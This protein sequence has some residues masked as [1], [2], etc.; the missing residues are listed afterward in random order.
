MQDVTDRTVFPPWPSFTEEE[1]D[2]VAA[3]LRSNK[4]NYWTAGLD[5]E[6]G[7][8]ERAFAAWS[9][10]KHAVALSNGTLA[11]ELIWSVLGIGAGDEVICT[12]RSFQAS[13][14]SIVMSGARP[15]FADVDPD[16]Q[17]ITPATVAPL[18]TERT[19]AILCVH[20]AG[21]PCDMAGFRQLADRHGLKLVEDCAQAHGA[22]IGGRPAGSFGDISA[23]S[24]CQDKII[25]TGGEGGMVTTGSDTLWNAAWSYKEHG[26]GRHAALEK[27]HPPGFRWLI[28]S[29]GTNGRMTEMQAAIGRIQVARM[30]EW[31]A[32]RQRNATLLFD[33]IAQIEALRCPKPPGD[34]THAWYKFYAFVRPDRLKPGWTR[35]R[36]VEEIA[37]AGVNCGSGSCPEMYREKPFVAAGLSTATRLPV[38]KELGE[39]SLMLQVHPTL[40]PQHMERIATVVR[41]VMR[42][43]TV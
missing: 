28:E 32:A 42:K 20:L 22:K 38:A 27:K 16:S 26:K 18:I 40:Q 21:W 9:D 13:A 25:T 43:A 19:R 35:D 5:G 23:W 34:I 33:G 6:V 12:P 2:A 10:T 17:N 37:A 30:P 11:L 4:V 36:I 14:S 3:V 7:Q 8:F 24:F 31:H 1:I 15:V 39:T 41:D 29:W